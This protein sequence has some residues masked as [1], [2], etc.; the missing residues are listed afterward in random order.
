MDESYFEGGEVGYSS[1]VDQ[2][3]SLRATFRRFLL[4][5]EKRNLTKGALLE[6]GCGYGYFLNEAKGFFDF[7]IGTD[8]SRR[9]VKEARLRAD[10]VYEKTFVNISSLEEKSLSPPPIWVVSGDAAC[11]NI[12]RLSRY[13]STCFILTGDHYLL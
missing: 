5:L 2:E 3:A 6:V 13:P 9:A 4:N 12:G 7:R 1:Y 8:F 10:Y 11:L